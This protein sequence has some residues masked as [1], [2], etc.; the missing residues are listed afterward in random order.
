M[1]SPSAA[2]SQ[3]AQVVGAGGDAGEEDMVL[4]KRGLGRGRGEGT[5]DLA[6]RGNIARSGIK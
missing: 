5:V 6:W 2:A 4:R 3:A 1:G